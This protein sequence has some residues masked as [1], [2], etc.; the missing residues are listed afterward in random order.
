[1]KTAILLRYLILVGIFSLIFVYC[2]KETMAPEEEYS[3]DLKGMAY[4]AGGSFQMGSTSGNPDEQPV[5]TVYLDSFYIDKHEV[6]NAKYAAYLN[7][8]IIAGEIQ[9]TNNTVTAN[10]KVLLDLAGDFCQIY[11]SSGTFAVKNGKE[12]YPVIYVTWYGADAYARHY[13]K[14]LPTE[15]EWEFAARGGL[16]SK[17]YN[18]S[19][20]NNLDKVAWYWDN[21][22]NPGNPMEQE[23]GTHTVGTKQSNELGIG[24]MNGNVLEW[25]NDW[26]GANYYSISSEINPPGPASGTLRVLRGG[27]W[28]SSEWSCRLSNR[29]NCEPDFANHYIGFRVVQDLK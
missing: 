12:N 15:A 22:M 27:Y 13:G 7:A 9:E 3:S 11:Y 23:K 29:A 28:L 25:C 18:Y 1:M 5:H 21:A 26:Y 16:H 6:T 24:D 8:A 20:S 19:G 17:G 14:R 2:E 4:V 10:G